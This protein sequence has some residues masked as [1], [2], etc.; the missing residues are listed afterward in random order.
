MI[1][2]WVA[3]WIRSKL[4]G[5]KLTVFYNIQWIVV[6]SVNQWWLYY[7]RLLSGLRHMK[8]CVDR[9]SFHLG[10]WGWGQQWP[11]GQRCSWSD[12][13]GKRRRRGGL[14]LLCLRAQVAQTQTAGA[15]VLLLVWSWWLPVGWH[16][17]LQGTTG[18]HLPWQGLLTDAPDPAQ[19]PLRLL[20]PTTQPAQATHVVS[21]TM[22]HCWDALGRVLALW[23]ESTAMDK[24]WTA[25]HLSYSV[26]NIIADYV[27]FLISVEAKRQL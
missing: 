17:T 9:S 7:W 3:G 21:N 10:R 19:P 24:H 8:K 15:W 27:C 13:L 14:L 16:N 2:E 4:V 5:I 26:S 23:A 25:A 18:S 12:G 22:W 1:N 11:Q 20:I 6:R